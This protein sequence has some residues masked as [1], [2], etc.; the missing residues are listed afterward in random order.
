M[1]YRVTHTTRYTYQHLVPLCQ[2]Q[3]HLA[4]RDTPI[5]RCRRSRLVV[6][7][8][9][10]ILEE[11]LDY[12]GNRTHYFAVETQHTELSVIAI[13]QLDI[14]PREAPDLMTSPAWETVRDDLQADFSPA[15]LEARFYVLNSPYVETSSDLLAFAQQV[16]SPQRPLLDAAYALMDLIFNEFTYDPNFT[17]LITPLAEV[18]E[19]KRGVCQDFSHLMIAAMRGLGLPAR[20]VS[21][22]L[23]TLPPPGQV[24]LQGADASHAWVSVY[25]PQNGWV[26]FDPTNNLIPHEQHITTAWGRDYQDVTPLRGVIYGGGT[27]TLTVGVDVERSE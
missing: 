2:N 1:K 17:T 18:L 8:R 10:V 23:E 21:G 6:R 4:L 5:Q 16:F 12:F 13:S 15:A 22:Y 27:H 20:Y 9:P 24:K 25:C 3:A 19:H 11:S 26:D 7:P 14:T